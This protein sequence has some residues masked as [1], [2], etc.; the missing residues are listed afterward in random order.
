MQ[1]Y[2]CKLTC[3]DI[4]MHVC[5]YIYMHVC[6]YMYICLVKRALC[7][8]YDSKHFTKGDFL[9]GVECVYFHEYIYINIYT[10]IYEHT[11]VYIY[12]YIHVYS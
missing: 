3:I 1:G 8:T 12:E 7:L 5:I 6:I 2:T 4:C 11:Y 10:Y 9:E